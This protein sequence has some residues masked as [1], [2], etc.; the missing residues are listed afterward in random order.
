MGLPSPRGFSSTPGIGLRARDLGSDPL[1]NPDGQWACGRRFDRIPWRVRVG[2]SPT[3]LFRGLLLQLPI[4]SIRKD[5]FDPWPPACCGR[6]AAVSSCGREG[7]RDRWGLPA[8]DGER[9]CTGRYGRRPSAARR[10]ARH[11]ESQSQRRSA[12]QDDCGANL[13]AESDHQRRA[14]E[15]P[16][17]FRPEFVGPEL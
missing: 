8:A 5:A 11:R 9:I 12:Q 16:D 6:D 2:L 1:P 7:H 14:V 10:G 3:S 15:L 4:A 13:V 17:L